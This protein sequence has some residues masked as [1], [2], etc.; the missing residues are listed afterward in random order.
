MEG[1]PG[2]RV[3]GGKDPGLPEGGG[4]GRNGEGGEEGAG[5][6]KEEEG[7]GWGQEEEVQNSQHPR[8]RPAGL[9][10]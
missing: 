9:F 7:G 1:D 2:G 10:R 4:F 6:E 5:G 8:H 3:G